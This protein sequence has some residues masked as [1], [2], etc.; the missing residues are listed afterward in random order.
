MSNFQ[1]PDS[2]AANVTNTHACRPPAKWGAGGPSV[3][4]PSALVASAPTAALGKRRWDEVFGDEV[5][6]VIEY[7]VASQKRVRDETMNGIL[8]TPQ[9]MARTCHK[10]VARIPKS[11]VIGKPKEVGRGAE[12]LATPNLQGIYQQPLLGP[13]VQQGWAVEA[14]ER[15]PTWVEGSVG[16]DTTQQQQR[17]GWQQQEQYFQIPN[18]KPEHRA[19]LAAAQDKLVVP[20]IRCKLCPG[21]KPKMWEDFK[22]Y[23]ETMEVH[24]LTITFCGKCGDYFARTDS[25][26]RHRETAPRACTDTS[27]ERAREKREWTEREHEAFKVRRNA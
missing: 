19:L 23:C 7:P 3:P 27:S 16:V 8:K 1:C 25:L 15:Q 11:K 12:R 14:A 26:G 24:P 6:G 22:R 20:E 18:L 21:T 13:S 2:D 4:T 9:S 5:R 17:Q 10:P